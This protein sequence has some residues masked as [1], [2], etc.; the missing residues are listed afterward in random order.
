MIRR[1][2][3]AVV[4]V[5]V[6]VGACSSTGDDGA[7]SP[8][9]DIVVTTSIWSDI[10]TNVACDG[11]ATVSTVVPPGV[12]PHAFEPSLSDREVMSGAKIVVSNGGGLEGGLIDTLDAV[13]SDGVPVVG[14]VDLVETIAPSNV[15]AEHDDGE[16]D[17]H[18]WL[19]PTRV[20]AA[21]EPLADRIASEL[22]LEEGSLDP[23]V[24]DYAARLESL[25]SEVAGLTEAVAEPRRQLVT[26]HDSLGYFADRYG[27]TVIG[28]IIPSTSSLAATNPS[29]LEALRAAVTASGVPAIF[30]ESTSADDDARALAAATGVDVVP[31]TV[32]TLGPSGSTTSTYID[33]VRST[34]EE[35]TSALADG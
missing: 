23:C 20:A 22:G 28:T 10:V 8:S 13:A 24:A 18:V 2:I 29:E 19:D 1:L 33:L 31:L 27:F 21:L 16:L 9:A 7:G 3:I 17:P 15:D 32:G 25:D 30:S 5:S 14:M 34:A 12:D 4:S 35:I 26:N 6:I 11:V